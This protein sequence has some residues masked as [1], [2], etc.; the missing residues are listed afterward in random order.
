MP[1]SPDS[2]ERIEKI[3]EPHPI[4]EETV[5]LDNE[6]IRRPGDGKVRIRVLT[7]FIMVKGSEVVYPYHQL[8]TPE[9]WKGV[10]VFGFT[11]SPTGESRWHIM[12]GLWDDT[13]G[14]KHFEV[15]RIRKV[16]GLSK[17]KNRLWRSNQEVALW[18]ESFQKISY[19]LMEPS[20]EYAAFPGWAETIR[21]WT[22]I[23]RCPGDPTV[24]LVLPCAP[25]P[26]WWKGDRAWNHELKKLTA[27]DDD[28]D[29]D[30]KSNPASSSR[31]GKGKKRSRTSRS[32]GSLSVKAS[33]GEKRKRVSNA[34][35][36][37]EPAKRRTASNPDPVEVSSDDDA[38]SDPEPTPGSTS[39]RRSSRLPKPVIRAYIDLS[40][41]SV[42]SD[43]ETTDGETSRDAPGSETEPLPQQVAPAEERIGGIRFDGQA[44]K[45]RAQREA[46]GMS[47]GPATQEA[48]AMPPRSAT[49][50][51]WSIESGG[52]DVDA[53]G[54]P[55]GLEA[56]SPVPPAE[57]LMAPQVDVDPSETDHDAT[58]QT[59][60]GRRTSPM[61]TGAD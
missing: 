49:S 61:A 44:A 41:D 18:L 12:G 14:S 32:R 33:R 38:A 34:N 26:D 43:P 57:V 23:P 50:P 10:E 9:F 6:H 1:V 7:W 2:L 17:E 11:A 13:Y 30:G 48:S 42:S 16:R 22:D 52:S 45:L 36:P 27:H 37:P 31:K 58:E 47:P 8:S 15:I 40:T 35:S 28:G 46:D 29:G 59:A 4:Q 53:Q 54:S 56:G 55:A 39:L 20:D 19:V 3:Y 60:M 5:F 25:R 21:T 24:H 51:R